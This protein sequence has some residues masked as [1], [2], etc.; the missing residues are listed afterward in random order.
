[1]NYR[2]VF[3]F[4]L[5]LLLLLLAACGNGTAPSGSPQS[6]TTPSGSAPGS[7]EVRVTLSDNKITSSLTTF[8]IGKPY[9]FVVTN[10]GNVAHQFVMVPMGMGLGRMSAD[11]MHR[12][13]LFMYESVAPGETRTFDYTFSPSTAGQRF[14][15]ACGTQGHYG[16]AE[17]QLP[18]IVNP[19]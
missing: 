3:G 2:R 5:A 18:F 7:Q 1:M 10:T 4:F 11:E 9:H 12:G 6:Q 14:K 13:A 16:G 15:F 19:Q 8:T 17:M